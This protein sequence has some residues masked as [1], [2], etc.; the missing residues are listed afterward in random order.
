VRQRTHVVS[1][2]KVRP[3]PRPAVEDFDIPIPASFRLASGDKLS[4][5]LVRLRRHG[6]PDAPQLAALGG[7]S[8][9]RDVCGEQGWWC[10]TFAKLDLSNVAVLGLDFAPLGDERVRITPLDQARLIEHALNYLEITR[11]SGFIGASYGGMIGLALAAHAPERVG[12]L[13]VISAAHRPAAQALAW[14]GVQRRMLEFALKHG[15]ADAGLSL[16]RQLAMITYRTP[17]EFEA[18]FGSGVDEDGLGE[19]D[20]YL[21]ARGNAYG[22]TMGPQRWLSLSE[23][24][25]R[26]IVDPTT[27][28][29]ST[30]VIACTSDQLAPLADMRALAT[31]L[32]KL[33]ALHELPSLYGHDAFLKEPEQLSAL[34]GGFIKEASNG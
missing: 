1:A 19:I 26:F 4:D 25:D 6:A 29:T 21:I 24:I 33:K 9:G 17:D 34:L 32:P 15:D 11:L 23:A 31:A 10:E 3:A 30:T 20:R 27:V 28:K 22:V 16:A 18:R 2:L 8:A 7:I 13:C 14:R 5:A 12:A